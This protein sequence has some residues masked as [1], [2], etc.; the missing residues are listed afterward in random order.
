M[1]GQD[2][3]RE[4]DVN[5]RWVRKAKSELSPV[6]VSK[7]YERPQICIT[8]SYFAPSVVDVK[9]GGPWGHRCMNVVEE[10]REVPEDLRDYLR[11]QEIDAKLFQV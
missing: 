4:V 11:R 3:I 6:D 10:T 1:G 2:R 9:D 5:R 8:K 7:R